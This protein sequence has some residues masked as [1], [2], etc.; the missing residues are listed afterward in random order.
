[1]KYL[2][3]IMIT[4]FA[5]LFAALALSAAFVFYASA[6]AETPTAD[7]AVAEVGL[8]EFT[9]YATLDEAINAA[10]VNDN[11]RLLKNVSVGETITVADGKTLN[12]D[13]N[14]KTMTYIGAT[15][16]VFLVGKDGTLNIIDNAATK[17]AKTVGVSPV[18]GETITCEGGLITGGKGTVSGGAVLGGAV[19]V[20]GGTFYLYGGNLAGNAALKDVA[21]GHGGA[22]RVESI[23]DRSTNPSVVTTLGAFYMSNAAILCNEA[24]CGGGVCV[25]DA[26][27]RIDLSKISYNTS[28]N[29]GGGIFNEFGSTPPADEATEYNLDIQEVEICGNSAET[30][31]GGIHAYTGS[32]SLIGGKISGNVAKGLN[33]GGGGLYVSSG[34][35]TIDGGTEVSGNTCE[36]GDGGGIYAKGTKNES[37]SETVTPDTVLDIPYATIS[38]NETLETGT[39]PSVYGGHGGGIYSDGAK[40]TLGYEII[41]NTATYGGGMFIKSGEVSMTDA[42][43]SA[44]T[45]QQD[46]GGI[47]IENGTLTVNNSDIS[48]YDEVDGNKA[49]GWGGGLYINGLG[50]DRAPIVKIVDGVIGY[51]T[52]TYYGGGGIAVIGDSIGANP[53]L[54]ISG[55]CEIIYNKTYWTTD[56]V[57]INGGGGLLVQKAYVKMHGGILSYN[58]NVQDGAVAEQKE[59]HGGG[60]YV[61]GSKLELIGVEVEYN[62]TLTDGGGIYA[63]DQDGGSHLIIGGGTLITENRCINTTPNSTGASAYLGTGGV[64]VEGNPTVEI[65]GDATIDGNFNMADKEDPGDDIPSNLYNNTSLSPILTVTGTRSENYSGKI[66]LFMVGSLTVT[67]GYSDY[68][69]DLNPNKVFKLDLSAFS[70]T[71]CFSSDSAGAVSLVRHDYQTISPIDYSTNYHIATSCAY[72]CGKA[73]LAAHIFAET[74]DDKHLVSPTSCSSGAVYHKSCACGHASKETFVSGSAD[75]T[76]HIFTHHDGAN[77]TCSAA[78]TKEYWNCSECN[79]NFSSADGLTELSDL[80]LPID[81]DAHILTHHD[82]ANATCSAAGTKEYWSCSECNKNFSSTDGATELSD[83]SLP[84]DPDA[85]I[86]T[87]HDGANATCSAAGTKEYWSCSECNKNFSSADGLAELTDLTVQKLPHTEVTIPAVA[88]TATA[89]GLTEGKKCSVCGEILVAQQVVPATGAPQVTVTVEGGSFDGHGKEEHSITVEDNGKVTVIAAEVEGKNFVG[90]SIDDGKTIV[91]GSMRYTFHAAGNTKIVAMYE[92]VEAG[93]GK[94]GLSGGAIAGIV[95]AGIFGLLVVLYLIGLLL[96]KKNVIDFKICKTLYFYV[97]K[98]QKTT[99]QTDMGEETEPI[100]A[101]EVTDTNESAEEIEATVETEAADDTEK[102]E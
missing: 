11:V 62:S 38:E 91:S 66:G 23:V 71:Y 27:V 99:G 30:I 47:K 1:M 57:A 77:A 60:A 20:K 40:V 6:S 97:K 59:Q 18:T 21:N 72:G 42:I 84:I 83:L 64:Y 96:Y 5:A 29:D 34:K 78:G 50:S 94:S 19:Y 75:P 82:G 22:V 49:A 92:P 31:G 100:D 4:A 9:P 46:G 15:G 35:V 76:K 51:N 80:S 37:G 25:C 85:H 17:T 70:K 53:D 95:I 24:D 7:T 45:A 93:D 16:S 32:M 58:S 67:N 79:K 90:W 48:G 55:N 56:T 14:D 98:E 10:G 89:A 43:V 41:G 54:D 26:Q 8:T 44:N 68:A 13:L 63:Q 87:H 28:T 101:V 86:L 52:T 88:P 69:G 61:Q 2:T 33:G 74:A 81:P 39:A 65:N 73:Q 102:T 36:G 3:K 12:L